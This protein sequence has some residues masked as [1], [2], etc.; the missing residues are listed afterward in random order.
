LRKEEQTAPSHTNG[1]GGDRV[2][3]AATPKYDWVP[4]EVRNER[5]EGMVAYILVGLCAVTLPILI[6]IAALH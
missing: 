3:K 6:L 1:G 5:T 4:H 2:K